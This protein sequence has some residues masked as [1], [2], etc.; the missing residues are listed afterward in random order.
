MATPPAKPGRQATWRRPKRKNGRRFPPGVIPFRCFVGKL[1]FVNV[2]TFSFSLSLSCRAVELY[3]RSE[4][5]LVE[6]A[7]YLQMDELLVSASV[8]GVRG[9]PLRKKCPRRLAA[10]RGDRAAAAARRGV[11]LGGES[12]LWRG[13]ERRGMGVGASVDRSLAAG[14]RWAPHERGGGVPRRRGVG[15]S[16]RS[17]AQ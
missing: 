17:P 10:C 2:R 4:S 8:G 7:A 5:E 3:I 11:S 12:K 16:A 15:E 14:G 6:G 13:R 1:R 9:A